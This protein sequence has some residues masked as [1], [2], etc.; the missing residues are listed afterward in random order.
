MTQTNLTNLIR[1]LK[2]RVPLYMK[3]NTRSAATCLYLLDKPQMYD[4]NT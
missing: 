3:K 1:D 2:K 4:V